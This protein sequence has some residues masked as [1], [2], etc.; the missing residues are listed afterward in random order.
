MSQFYSGPFA[1]RPSRKDASG[2]RQTMGL[3]SDLINDRLRAQEAAAWDDN[4]SGGGVRSMARVYNDMRRKVRASEPS[5]NH[6]DDAVVSKTPPITLSPNEEYLRRTYGL[7]GLPSSTTSSGLT[8]IHS[9]GTPPATALQQ[10]LSELA[11]QQQDRHRMLSVAATTPGPSMATGLAYT[12]ALRPDHPWSGS[13]DAIL[14]MLD[15]MGSSGRWPGMYAPS[16][17]ASLIG[18][19]SWS[20]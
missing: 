11:R 7:G 3:R 1:G 10:R 2:R 16:D 9:Y 8:D 15:R 20:R 6:G 13:R 12:D 17:M 18:G 14:R 19:A 4:P 5:W